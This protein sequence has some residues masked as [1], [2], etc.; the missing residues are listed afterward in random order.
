[1]VL[2][3]VE[4][5]RGGGRSE[6]LR[7]RGA[8]GERVALCDVTLLRTAI[9]TLLRAAILTIFAWLLPIFAFRSLLLPIFAR[10]L[11]LPKERNAH[12]GRDGHV[13]LSLWRYA[14]LL[15]AAILTIFAWPLSLSCVAA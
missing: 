9:L 6:A 7:G 3:P 14:T 15:R 8:R 10:P 1:M 2:R 13:S 4:A 12:L 5:T 11:R